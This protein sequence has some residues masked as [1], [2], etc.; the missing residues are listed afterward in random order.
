MG[1]DARTASAEE[2][3]QYLQRLIDGIVS[4]VDGVL[5]CP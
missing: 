4:A 2:A 1:E 5:G 3:E